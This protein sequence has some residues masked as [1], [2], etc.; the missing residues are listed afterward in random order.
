MDIQQLRYLVALAEERSFTRAAAREHIAQPALSQQIRR[1]EQETGL[2]LAERTTRSV[3]ITAAGELLVARARRILGELAAAGA[4]LEGLRGVKTG[5]VTIGA[6]PTMGAIDISLPLS[7]FHRRH[8]LVELTVREGLSDELGE[9]LRADLLDLAFLSVTGFIELQSHRVN[10]LNLHRL[11]DEELVLVLPRNHSLASRT[12]IRVAELADETFVSYRAGA[13]LREIL[14]DAGRRAGFEP[15]VTF[16]SSESLPIR[17]LVN[18]GMGVAML[19]RSDAFMPGPDVA[20]AKLTAPTLMRDITIAW[21]EDRRLSP[22][23]AEFVGLALD[24]FL[25][26]APEDS[27]GA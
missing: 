13:Q 18:R 6:I 4:E 19:P 17:A 26:T 27:A 22:A 7:I 23:A 9:M 10:G 3:K 24:V 5:H 25:S 16:E 14:I 8:P 2:A 12:E 15:K 20:V 1:L 11:L 21:R